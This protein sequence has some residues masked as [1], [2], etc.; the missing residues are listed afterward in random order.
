MT[1]ATRGGVRVIKAADTIR[2]R[3]HSRTVTAGADSAASRRDAN[4][5]LLSVQRVEPKGFSE[6]RVAPRDIEAAVGRCA[7]KALCFLVFYLLGDSAPCM[8]C[9]SMMKDCN[10]R[11]ACGKSYIPL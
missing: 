2:P 9:V 10:L 1:D 5:S 8:H 4:A 6:A 3:N 7:L 11:K